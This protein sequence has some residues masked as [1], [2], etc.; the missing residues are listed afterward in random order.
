MTLP[1]LF[2]AA[3]AA[4]ALHVADDRFIHPQPGTSA[5][6]HLVSG[7]VPLALLALAF[8]AFPRVKAG[9]QGL[10]AVTLGFLAAA[11]A[12]EGVYYTQK[13]GPAGDD[14]TSLLAA[15]AA[16]AFFGVAAAALW[17][18]RRPAG[19]PVWRYVRRAL[20]AFA[21]LVVVNFLVVPVGAA[22]VF[23]HTARAVVPADRLGVAHEDVR[24]TTEDGLELEGWYVPSRNGAAVIAFPGRNGPQKQARMLA[25]HGYGVLL[26]DRRGEGR[27]DGDP[28]AFGWGGDRDVKAAIAYLQ[29]RPDVDPDRIGG[30]GL[31]VGGEL[32]LEVAAETDDLRAVVSE[33]AGSR[34]YSEEFD[35]DFPAAEHVLNASGVVLKNVGLGVF[36]DE[37]P[38]PD[39]ETLVGRIAPRPLLLIAAPNSPNGEDLNVQYHDAANEP[40]ELW[41]IPESGH[42]GGIDAR[43]DEYER[44]VVGFF[45]RSL[46]R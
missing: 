10:L 19:R 5:G 39:L 41:Q 25:A 37:P 13:L 18:S 17:T 45:D 26:F 35:H 15:P 2:R 32:M 7:L 8:W 31:S 27:S 4:L 42:T 36:G 16:L 21:G 1:T 20:L 22:Y 12:V 11:G 46:P 34:M 14:F 29:Q 33:G 28:N 23:T 40:K 44:R 38:P 6:D 3:T 30:I 43:P 9:A 24:F